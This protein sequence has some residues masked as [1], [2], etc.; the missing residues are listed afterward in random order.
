MPR[1]SPFKKGNKIF[2]TPK[3]PLLDNSAPRPGAKG[4]F[5][6]IEIMVVLLIIGIVAGMVAMQV[7][8]TDGVYLRST[9]RNLV[10]TVRLTYSVAA[11]NRRPYRLAFDLENQLVW[12]ETK[13]GKDY[14]KVDEEGL[15]E[16]VIPDPVYI[17]RIEVM[18]RVC[19]D[20]CV[21]YIYFTPGGYVEEASIYL[22]VGPEEEARTITI[23]T[24]SMTG[25]AVIVMEEISR[26]DWENEEKA[27]R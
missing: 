4:G 7:T 10:G 13:Q 12:L 16:R 19:E 25:R 22:A 21:E 5:T 11:L 3:P 17:K 26:E 27:A 9:A 23:F 18:D 2:P 20:Y 1:F 24:R 15:G 8:T 14:V 6:L